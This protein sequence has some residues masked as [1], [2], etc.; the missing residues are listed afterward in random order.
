MPEILHILRSPGYIQDIVYTGKPMVVEA[1]TVILLTMRSASEHFRIF[2]L[3][4]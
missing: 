2:L 3:V 1:S 4:V